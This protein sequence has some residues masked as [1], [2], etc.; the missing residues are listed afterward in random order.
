[1]SGNEAMS[2]S[3]SSTEEAPKC[4]ICL[5]GESEG[6]MQILR[7]GH[8][9]HKECLQQL[10]DVRLR[11]PECRA[12]VDSAK[13]TKEVEVEE[14]EAAM[15]PTNTYLGIKDRDT[16]WYCA[17]AI[18]D[19]AEGKEGVYFPGKTIDQLLFISMKMHKEDLSLCAQVLRAFRALLENSVTDD[20]DFMLEPL[21]D[22]ESDTYGEDPVGF[23]IALFEYHMNAAHAPLQ[24]ETV[25][26]SLCYIL[27]NIAEGPEGNDILRT[28]NS[29]R[30][31]AGKRSL[32][33]LL[34]ACDDQ[35]HED[36]KTC[37]NI[38][39]FCE[40][41]FRHEDNRDMLVEFVEHQGVERLF[42]DLAEHQADKHLCENVCYAFHS[43]LA[44]SMRVSDVGF[45]S[46]VI[47]LTNVPLLLSVLEGHQESEGVVNAIC[48][49]L[50][51][52][53]SDITS[54][55][56]VPLLLSLLE[57]HQKSEG[58][59]YAICGILQIL[60]LDALEIGGRGLVELFVRLLQYHK[61]ENEVYKN[62]LLAFQRIVMPNPIMIGYLCELFT[63]D[64]FWEHEKSLGERYRLFKLNSFFV[65][66]G[67]F[68]RIFKD[69]DEPL[70]HACIPALIRI[71]L[72]R[73]R[74]YPHSAQLNFSATSSFVIAYERFKNT[75]GHEAD[76]AMFRAGFLHLPSEV[77]TGA[78]AMNRKSRKTYRKNRKACR[79]ASRKTR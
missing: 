66:L 75:P 61:G 9:L 46:H 24:S 6:I 15:T 1:M 54:L 22:A 48:H 68:A 19:K 76:W 40:Q 23:M 70:C 27:G 14:L 78:A 69:G 13:I 59:V 44:S 17:K 38:W 25:C 65:F 31:A 50:Q 51:I 29:A 56:N 53:P 11:C 36:S 60:P 72:E 39:Y 20:P 71:D 49:I 77:A 30:I 52:F 73:M 10:L 67:G 43:L 33:S 16:A 4:P 57:R 63:S 45:M 26:L 74:L 62:I 42:R 47:S 34:L 3:A 79:K 55:I 58:I 8:S 18:G 12:I 37:A 28:A 5:E 7:C 64:A 2:S 32:V 35:H 21:C 41:L